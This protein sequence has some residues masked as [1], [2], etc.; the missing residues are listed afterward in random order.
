MFNSDISAPQYHSHHQVLSARWS[1]TGRD[2]G[3]HYAT[4]S[5][6]PPYQP[7]QVSS[8]IA[9]QLYLILISVRVIEICWLNWLEHEPVSEG[10]L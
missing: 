7:I 9:L 8:V 5:M 2:T 4:F 3:K 1:Y 10:C 6:P